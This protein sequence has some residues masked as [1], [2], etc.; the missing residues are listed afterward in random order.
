MLILFSI[1]SN[2]YL[3]LIPL[4]IANLCISST[5]TLNYTTIQLLTD[6]HQRGRVSSFVVL[7]FGFTPLGVI[8]LAWMAKHLGI[9]MT[10]NI[11]SAVLI[12]AVFAML[13]LLPRFKHID[14]DVKKALARHTL[15]AQHDRQA[16]PNQKP[17]INH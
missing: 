8:P 1:T 6:D 16:Q 13:A 2:F 10:I 5:H 14:D 12:V 7:M 9:A 11:A 17:Q 4:L 3:A 15:K